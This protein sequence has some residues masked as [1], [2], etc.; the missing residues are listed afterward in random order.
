M[1]RLRPYSHMLLN[2][3]LEPPNEEAA[4]VF[5]HGFERSHTLEQ[6]KVQAIDETLVYGMN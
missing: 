3:L 2:M 5:L 4:S 6:E 1:R